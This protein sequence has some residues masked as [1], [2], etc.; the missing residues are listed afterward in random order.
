LALHP[1]QSPADPTS[2]ATCSLS[3][4]RTKVSL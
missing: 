4:T 1:F 3:A 2:L